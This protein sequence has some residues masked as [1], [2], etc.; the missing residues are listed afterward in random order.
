MEV[1]G[2]AVAKSHRVDRHCCRAF[3]VGIAVVVD[4]VEVVRLSM[5]LGKA[6]GLFGREKCRFLLG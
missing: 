4:I 2:E 6:I 5:W 3:V 1:R